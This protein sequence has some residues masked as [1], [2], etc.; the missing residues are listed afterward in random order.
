MLFWQQFENKNDEEA[1]KM[2]DS[3]RQEHDQ[4]VSALFVFTVHRAI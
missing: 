1:A 4:V 3:R 2:T